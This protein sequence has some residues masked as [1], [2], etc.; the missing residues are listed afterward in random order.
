MASDCA[1][2]LMVPGAMRSLRPELALKASCG[3]PHS[4][5]CTRGN[6]RNSTSMKG[7]AW[8]S[9]QAP[10]RSGSAMPPRD[11]G[12]RLISAAMMT[13]SAASASAAAAMP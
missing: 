2:S 7:S 3:N 10:C 13:T 1:T 11:P 9:S 12:C 6:S 4:G 8:A 5:P